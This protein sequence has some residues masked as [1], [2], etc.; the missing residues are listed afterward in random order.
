MSMCRTVALVPALAVIALLAS[1]MPAVA[2]QPQRHTVVDQ[3]GLPLPGVRIDVRRNDQIVENVISKDDGT[4][5]LTGTLE[6][7]TVEA[8][9]DG[10]ETARVPIAEA[11]HIVLFLAHTNEVTEVTASAL[12]SSGA[13]MARLGSTMSAQLALR[14]P[15]RRPRILQSLPNA[16]PDRKSTR[17]NSSHSAKS[18]MP[19]SA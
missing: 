11:A 2:A 3:T 17:L 12:V 18:R 16:G 6:G 4:F 5:E 1:V 19:S 14:L 10:F 13:A 8:A 7:D 15:T 9:L